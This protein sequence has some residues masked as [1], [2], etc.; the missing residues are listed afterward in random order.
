MSS[1]ARSLAASGLPLPSLSIAVERAPT[2]YAVSTVDTWGRLADRS[3][4]LKLGW[5]PG[6]A[7]AI[8]VTGDVIAVTVQCNGSRRIA[9]QGYLRLPAS[10]RSAAHVRA[11]DR[12]LLAAH[13]DQGLLIAYPPAVLDAM[14]STP[15]RTRTAGCV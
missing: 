14:V 15:D 8:A 7:I 4:L 10:V 9:P 2:F 11:G 12:L 3:A 6:T 5:R 13:L 1:E